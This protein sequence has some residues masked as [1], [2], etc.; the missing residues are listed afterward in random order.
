MEII[1]HWGEVKI[2][3]STVMCQMRIATEKS[4]EGK[5]VRKYQGSE[6]GSLKL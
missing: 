1:L 2:N 6:E 3:M 5:A 4:T